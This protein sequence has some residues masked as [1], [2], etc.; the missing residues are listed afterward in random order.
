[1]SAFVLLDNVVTRVRSA[2]GARAW[3]LALL[4][5]VAPGAAF[6]QATNSIQTSATASIGRRKPAI[7]AS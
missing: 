6:A 7:S 3:L 2:Q 5:L 4:T 1:M